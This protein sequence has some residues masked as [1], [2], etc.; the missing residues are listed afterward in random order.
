MS[1]RPNQFYHKKL[2]L[3]KEKDLGAAC[4]GVGTHHQKLELGQGEW[5]LERGAAEPYGQCCS[6]LAPERRQVK[7]RK[8]LLAKHTG[9][10]NTRGSLES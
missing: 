6:I 3:I 7:G 10:P 2:Y 5:K 4:A 8:R 9:M 1:K